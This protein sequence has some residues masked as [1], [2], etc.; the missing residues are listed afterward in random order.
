MHRLST[1][2]PMHQLTSR[3]SAHWPSSGDSTTMVYV[4]SMEPCTAGR[5]CTPC[6]VPHRCSRH[7]GQAWTSQPWFPGVQA[8]NYLLTTMLAR[9][10]QEKAWTGLNTSSPRQALWCVQH[11]RVQLLHSYTPR[12]RPGA[13]PHLGRG[14][15]AARLV[16]EG[17][18]RNDDGLLAHYTR[19]PAVAASESFQ[20]QRASLRKSSQPGRAGAQ[21]HCRHAQQ[22][23]ADKK[24]C[25]HCGTTAHR[26]S[27]TLPRPSMT[28]LHVQDGTV[29]PTSIMSLP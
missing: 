24:R 6:H 16:C 7:M 3:V 15:R 12:R 19:S 4:P 5:T 29:S 28:I 2:N 25:E 26:T 23:L 21:A 17:L 13:A 20:T 9:A 22:P 1:C 11:T 10:Q 8:V 18:A 14:E 27:S